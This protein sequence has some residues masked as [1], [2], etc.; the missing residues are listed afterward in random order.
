MLLWRAAEQ[1][2]IEPGAVDRAES[3]GLLEVGERVVFRHPLV[4]SAVYGSAAIEDRRVVHSALADVTDREVDP[5]RR[6]WHLA[7]ATAGPDE[8]VAAELDRSSARAQARGGVAAAAAFLKR[9]V[10]LTLDPGRRAVRALD[11]AQAYLQAGAFDAALKLLATAEVGPLDELGL[12]KVE[13]VRGQ[14]AFASAW[15][16]EAPAL[17]LKAARRLEALDPALARETYLDAWGAALY[18]GSFARAS[19]HE[20]ARAALSAPQPSSA[21]RPNDLLLVGFAVLVTDGRVAAA[22]KLSRAA[23]MFAQGEVDIAEGLRWGWLAAPAAVMLWA[24][25]RWWAITDRQLQSGREA[26][27][28]VHLPAYLHS[29]AVIAAWRGDFA[30][31]ASLIAEQDAVAEATG[32]HFARYAAVVLACW[33]GNDAEAAALIEVE[34]RTA[35]AAGQGVAIQLCQWASAILF[36]GLGRYEQALAE[37]LRA[38][39]S[40]P[41]LFMSGWALPEL[42]E[43][44]ARTGDTGLAGEAL[45]RLV[46][47]TSVGESDWGLGVLAR[48]RALLSQ[49]RD[50][51]NSYLEAIARLSRTK[52]RPELARAHLLYGEWLRRENR[53]LDAREQLRTAHVMFTTMGAEAFAARAER[54]L[55]ATGETARKRTAETRDDL[56]AQE[57][58]IAQLARDGLSNPEIGARLFISPRTVEYHLHKVFTKLEITSREHLDRVL[59]S[60]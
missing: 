25:E 48:S 45:E 24:E 3:E 29:L 28:L 16:G 46:E 43:A 8:Q 52:L 5:D 55:R 38:S 49:G 12:A 41:E 58:Q 37:A 32:T 47:A 2:G 60:N 27:L 57:A 4:R 21:P 35:S 23:S 42:I 18:A 6:A 31:S 30:M 13:V 36:N 59:P 1:L 19:V 50:A 7:A 53:R 39:E 26:G 14:I 15:G 51:A 20:V 34:A 40:A 11:A 56:T 9:S 17:L 44:A 33:R 10:A 22:F 54:E